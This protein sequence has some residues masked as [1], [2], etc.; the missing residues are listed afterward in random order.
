MHNV[1][2]FQIPVL[3]LS[4]LSLFSK[5]LA[6]DSWEGAVGSQYKMV[7]VYFGTRQFGATISLVGGADGVL[8]AQLGK[9]Y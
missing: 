8:A 9:P 5:I 7:H 2:S 6:E 1:G 4:S 3:I